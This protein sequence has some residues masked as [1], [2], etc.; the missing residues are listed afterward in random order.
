MAEMPEEWRYRWCE[1]GIC[2]CIGA[3]N[4]SGGLSEKG[5]TKEDH[6][7]WVLDNPKINVANTNDNLSF[8]EMMDE[9]QK[10]LTNALKCNNI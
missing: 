8:S 5:F 10:Q 7:S 9:F 6:Q 4:C 1:N 3:A 2:G